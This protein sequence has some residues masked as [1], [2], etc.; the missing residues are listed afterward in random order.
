MFLFFGISSETSCRHVNDVSQ[1]LISIV[2]MIIEWYEAV[3]LF[4]VLFTL[5][6]AN[7]NKDP[8]PA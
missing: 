3:G 1:S 4:C 6:S 2:L 8:H 7:I 5:C